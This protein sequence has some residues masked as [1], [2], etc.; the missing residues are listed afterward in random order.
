MYDTLKK[1]KNRIN[2]ES[3]KK[4]VEQAQEKGKL[5]KEEYKLLTKLD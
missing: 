1:L 2:S 4:M 5:T 3:W